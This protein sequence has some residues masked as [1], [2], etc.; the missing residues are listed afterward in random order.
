MNIDLK[1]N[2]DGK[3]LFTP[4]NELSNKNKI[5][6][7]F[8]EYSKEIAIRCKTYMFLDWKNKSTAKKVKSYYNKMLTVSD[9]ISFIILS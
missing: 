1:I 6:L 9:A 2:S 3:P 8:E 7:S 5:N 4:N